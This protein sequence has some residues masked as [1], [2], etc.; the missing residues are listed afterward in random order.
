MTLFR[1]LYPYSGLA[2]KPSEKCLYI[3]SLISPNEEN[4]K[5][6]QHPT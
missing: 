4:K 2:F 6:Y 1:Y 5:K 3:G